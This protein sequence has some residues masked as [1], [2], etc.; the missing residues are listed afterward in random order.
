MIFDLQ[1]TNVAAVFTEF[2]YKIAKHVAV[3][4]KYGRPEAEKASN[5]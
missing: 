1:T 5:I 3:D 2:R 4:F